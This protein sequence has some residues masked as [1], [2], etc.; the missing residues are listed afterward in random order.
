[1]RRL[2]PLILLAI[3]MT[4]CG[5]KP[6]SPSVVTPPSVSAS[7]SARQGALGGTGVGYSNVAAPTIGQTLAASSG[8]WIHDPSNFA[9][10]WEDCDILG[11]NCAAIPG[12][13]NATYTIGIGDSNLS[14]R[15]VVTASNSAGTANS[16]SSATEPSIVTHIPNWAYDDACGGGAGASAALV[17]AWVTDAENNCGGWTTGSPAKSLRDCVVSGV[18]YCNVLPYVDTNN[19]YSGTPPGTLLTDAQESWFLHEASPNQATRLTTTAFGGGFIMNQTTPA[20]QSWWRTFIAAQYPGATGLFMDDQSPTY[21]FFG[22]ST[23]TST[24]VTSVASEEAAHTSISNSMINSANGQLYPQYDNTIPDCGNNFETSQGIGA[25]GNMITGAVQGLIAE[26]CPTENGTLIGFYAGLLDDMSWVDWNTSGSITLLSFGATGAGYQ[27]QERLMQIATILMGYSPGH[28]V[29]WSELEQSNTTLS[30]FPESGIVPTNPVQTM[31]NPGG[32]NCLTLNTSSTCSTGGHNDVLTGTSGVY[33]R[34]FQHC[35][36]QGTLVGQCAVV[37]NTTGSAVT[38][39]GPMLT[40]SYGHSVTLSGGD[41]QGGGTIN[42]SGATFTVG[43]TQ[44]AADSAL[45]LTP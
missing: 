2:L 14:V 7:V 29:D 43:T 41:V 26:G 1:M 28:T 44:V 19:I 16:S 11:T 22:L 30:V 13:N 24:E 20:Y 18:T 39:S 5:S 3:G 35:Y 45:I 32:T 27:T 8:T 42:V 10:Q 17:H 6:Q 36:N 31:A 21:P 12:A 25:S 37:V 9:Y 34:E 38:V 15:V 23:T 40:Q 4:A 33:R